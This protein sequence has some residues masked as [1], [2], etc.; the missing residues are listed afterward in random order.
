[1]SSGMNTEQAKEYAKTMTYSEAVS[2]VRY[3]KGIKYRKATMI[4]LRELAI[5]ADRLDRK[6]EPQ[7][8]V[9]AC[10]IID[11]DAWIYEEYRKG[12]DYAWSIAQKV[13]DSTVTFYEAEDVA[14]Q[15]DKDINVRSKDCET[16]NHYR[17][18]CD[19]FSEICKYEP[20][21]EPQTDISTGCSKCESR[22]WCD[23]RDRPNAVHCN[24]YGK[25]EP[26]IVGKHADVI[27]IDEPQTCNDCDQQRCET[28]VTEVGRSK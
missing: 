18:T 14:K 17:L 5:I 6:D 7:K 12:I 27:I 26:H 20:K 15:I 9:I 23:D 21:D 3:S 11:D 4:K 2:N 25:T 13:F 10:P 1:M 24:N 16:C 8:E 28:C 22:Y 19:L